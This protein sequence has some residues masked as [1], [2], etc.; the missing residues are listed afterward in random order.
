MPGAWDQLRAFTRR[1][2]ALVLAAAA[3]L[4]VAVVGTAVSLAFAVRSQRAERRAQQESREAD[5]Q[6]AR[7]ATA[8]QTLVER[9]LATTFRIMPAVH[10]LPGGAPLVAELMAATVAELEELEDL[11]RGDPDVELALAEAYIGLGD[12]YGNPEVANLRQTQRAADAYTRA[13]ALAERSLAEVGLTGR[14]AALVAART[15]RRRA[16]L[17]L[18]RRDPA[19]ASQDLERGHALATGALA[20]A[21]SPELAPL[22]FELGLLGHLLSVRDKQDGDLER[23]ERHARNAL[24]HVEAAARGGA[25][26]VDRHVAA[27]SY[28]LGVVLTERGDLEAGWSALQRAVAINERVEGGRRV[29]LDRATYL[30]GLGRTERRMR[31]FEDADANLLAARELLVTLREEDPDDG[32]VL[33]KWVW[34]TL[35]W[36]Y[37]GDRRTDTPR[38]AATAE[39]RRRAREAAERL[40]VLSPRSPFVA[41][42]ERYAATEDD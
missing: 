11:A 35:E 42:L 16:E 8:F 13:L 33:P 17:A 34:A 10:D 25:T 41:S 19:G 9:G 22:R 29:R 2:R 20:A 38:R 5:T 15:L 21:A 12:V 39:G 36:L 37:S 3:I 14:R 26:G 32:R 28:W 27:K 7:A 24:E 40:K 30:L 4:V 1:N 31:R 18:G 23:A 6:R